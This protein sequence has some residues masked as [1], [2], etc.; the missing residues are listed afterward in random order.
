MEAM[1]LVSKSDER[2]LMTVTKHNHKYRVILLLMLDCGLRVTECVRVKVG[3]IE[4][5]RKLVCVVSLKKRSAN[6]VIRKIPISHRLYEAL[7]SYLK[8]RKLVANE[9][10]FP[11]DSKSGHI[12]RVAVWKKLKSDS[13]QVV[14]PHMLR[15][16]FATKIIKDNDLYTTRDL[17]GHASIKT[18]EIYTHT[19][20]N[21]KIKA[22]ESIDRVGVF[23]KLRR[24]I[25]KPKSI[26]M[27]LP[28]IDNV[29]TVG[30]VKEF[31][32]LNSNCEKK[33]N[34]YV[35]GDM[36]VGKSHLL[37]SLRGKDK[38]LWLDDFR[39]VKT[40]IANLLDYL[41]THEDKKEMI[42]L[43]SGAVLNPTFITKKSTQRL[44]E[45]VI[46]CTGKNEY[47]L[48]I[49]DLTHVTKSGASVL[50]KLKDHFHMVVAARRLK[51][52]MS[53]FLSNFHKISIVP[54]SRNDSTKLIHSLSRHMRDRIEDYEAYK[55]Y[56]FDQS[57]GNALF[58]NELVDRL[59]KENMITASELGNVS[60]MHS[61]KYIDFT[62]PIIIGISSLMVLRYIGGEMGQDSGA[63]K[64]F[65]GVF[66][67]FALFA[68]SLFQLSRR[69]YV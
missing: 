9:F 60:H 25:V 47:T 23:E 66:M 34:T 35:E 55:N 57:G 43:L 69:K 63:F 30:R 68:R 38:V 21:D 61:K 26:R 4:F 15:H 48:V 10:L 5:Q 67:V 24:M 8:N 12:S 62:L 45:L 14:Y 42:E 54:F 11:S 19:T 29:K 52:D 58:I 64:L 13:S 59:D 3:D 16:T 56:V 40:T 41:A 46:G 22:I 20:L 39:S 37:K 17:L 49:D 31:I 44:L 2:H 7:A 53:S 32:E 36:G 6:P 65:G 33:I 28:K 18:T 27:P 1:K 51:I 50:E